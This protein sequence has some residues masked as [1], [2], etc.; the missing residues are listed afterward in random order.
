MS[1]ILVNITVGVL[2]LCLG[3]V[4]A[5]QPAVSQVSLSDISSDSASYDGVTVDVESFVSY[6][7]GV[8]ALGEPFEKPEVIAFLNL[9]G[10]K[11]DIND[12]RM[13]LSKDRTKREYNRAKVRV[14]GVL[15]DNCLD[16][17]CCFGRSVGIDVISLTQLE[18]V[19]R[20]ELPAQITFPGY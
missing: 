5:Y 4:T 18:S 3:I 19:Q 10:I 13:E 11:V 12:L 20:Y 14:I 7:E 9:D 17:T 16:R 15:H 6:D 8:W 2:S 1:R